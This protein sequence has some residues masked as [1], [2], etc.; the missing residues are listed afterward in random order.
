MALTGMTAHSY[1]HFSHRY[2]TSKIFAKRFGLTDPWRHASPTTKTFSFFSHVHHTYTRID[3][4]RLDDRLLSMIK[5]SDYHSIVISDHAPTSLD[6]YFHAH[7]N[8]FRQWRFNSSLLAED[9]YKWFIH[10]QITLFF[11]LNDLPDTNRG[12]LW[13]ASKAYIRGQLISFVSNLKR[14]EASQTVDLLQKIK[15]IDDK[16]VTDPDPIL[17]RERLRL[18]TDFDLLSTNKARL[19]LLK[20][21]QPFLESGD[22]AGKLLA[23][24]AR[25]EATLRLIPA[26]RANSGEIHTDPATINKTFA[27]FYADLY[28]SDCPPCGWDT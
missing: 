27:Q 8:P 1:P 6:L 14:V 15:D 25:A 19:C 12:V 23:H 3:F 2:Q 17:Y 16:Y 7:S 13:E 21:R 20:S 9:L 26:I 10:T 4:F 24:Q 28:S 18:Q 5:S 11:E 22:K